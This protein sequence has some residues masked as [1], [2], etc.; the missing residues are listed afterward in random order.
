MKI[1]TILIVVLAGL[2][3]PVISQG[4]GLTLETLHLI[5]SDG[6]KTLSPE[7]LKSLAGQAQ[8][9]LENILGF[10]SANP[11]ID[12][13][14][15]IRVI[16][17]KPRRDVYSSVFYWDTKGGKKTRV[18]GVFGTEG[19]PQMMAHK[20]TS[21]IFPQKDKL[22]R[23][24]MGILTE[25]QVGNPLTFPM[26]GFDNDDWVLAL[27]KSK[28]YIPIDQLGPDHESWGMKDEGEGRLKI[29]DKA[30]QHKGYAESGSFG[31]YLFQTYGINKIK[32]F[33]KLSHEK[34]RPWKDVFQVGLKEL[35]AHWINTLRVQEKTREENVSLLLKLLD[36]NPDTACMECQKLLTK[37]P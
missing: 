30:K 31:T 27:L 19:K 16:F 26:C 21:A 7:Q 20:L 18:V 13:F 32:Q 17:D 36:R 24:M 34:D 3:T 2:V 9:M 25:V 12:R 33:N 5:V 37:K 14:G 1:A 23:N 4:S 11:G 15:K 6:T 22:I 28:L 35:E 29:T 10:W 8:A